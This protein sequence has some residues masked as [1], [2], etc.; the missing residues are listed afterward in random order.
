[1]AAETGG[2]ARGNAITPEGRY[3]LRPARFQHSPPTAPKAMIN[4]MFKNRCPSLLLSSCA[5]PASVRVCSPRM[6]Q[7]GLVIGS[8]WIEKVLAG[9]KTW[10]I[11]NRTPARRP[12][13]RGP[14]VATAKH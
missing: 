4:P 14:V 10:E 1:M 12:E 3:F 9:E 6:T 5:L 11:R 2:S 13:G 8:P 7:M